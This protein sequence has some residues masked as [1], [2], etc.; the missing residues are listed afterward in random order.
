MECDDGLECGGCGRAMPTQRLGGLVNR[1]PRAP[2]RSTPS[3]QR[4]QIIGHFAQTVA[5][6]PDSAGSAPQTGA[7]G[8]GKLVTAFS[9]VCMS[10]CMYVCIYNNNNLF[11]KQYSTCTYIIADSNS[12]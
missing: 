4:R 7:Y 6:Y 8:I 2:Y 12:Y 1:G 11:V 3:H 10:V 5:S 9:G